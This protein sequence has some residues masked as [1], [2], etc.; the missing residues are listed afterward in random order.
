MARIQYRPASRS[1]GFRPQQLSTA[2]ISRMREEGNRLIQGME[3]RRRAE[4][5]QRD[6]NLRA[7]ESDARYTEQLTRENNAI[8]QRNLENEGKQRIADIQGARDQ[9]LIDEK[10][11]QSI[12]D[13]IISFSTTAAEQQA[14]RRKEELENMAAEINSRPLTSYSREELEQRIAAEQTLAFGGVQNAVE[15][16]AN[17]LETNEDPVETKKAHASNPGTTAVERQLVTNNGFLTSGDILLTGRYNDAETEYTADDGT[18]FKGIEAK[19]SRYLSEQLFNITLKDLFKLTGVADGLYVADAVDKLRKIGEV[20]HNQA[21]KN[22]G[23]LADAQVESTAKNIEAA[24]TTEAQTLAFAHRK[25]AQGNVEALDAFE[26]YAGGAVDVDIEVFRQVDLKGN[27]K[28]FDQEWPE[29]WKKILQNR[30]DAFVKQQDQ[31][32]KLKKA[33]DLAWFNANIDNIQEAVDLNPHQAERLL[34]ERYN[35]LGITMPQPLKSIV[36]EGL[37]RNKEEVQFQ[38]D[39]RTKYGILDTSFV[40][41]IRDRTQQSLAR[42]A[43]QT[44]EEARYGPA[45]L[46]IKKGFK[47]TARKLTKINPNEEQ[48]SAQT[49]LVQA[50]LESE[51]LKQVKLTNDPLAALENVNAMVDAGRNGD[52][53]SPFY[54]D[55]GFLNNRLVFPNIE[56]SD[57]ERQEKNQYIDKQTLRYGRTVVDKP[58]A[59]ASS[60]EMDAAYE[61]SVAGVIKYPA[62]ILRVADATGMK[63]S[64]VYNAHRMANN[65]AT[66]D[67][68]PML[69]DS[70]ASV[71]VDNV[72]PKIRK[73]LLSEDPF[74]VK[75]G[76]AQITGDLGYTRQERKTIDS[77]VDMG[78]AAGAKFPEL[79]AAQMILESALGTATSGTNNFFGMKAFGD[80]AFTEKQT[81]EFYDGV[82]EVETAYFKNYSS[83]EESVSDLVT[84]WYKDYPGY[85]GI[86][87]ATSLEEAAM[88]LQEQGYATDPNYAQKLIEIA[89]RIR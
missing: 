2:G 1:K 36:A 12:F 81:T 61:S 40:N 8:Q 33:E 64:E 51:F 27:G 39:Q 65:A 34:V 79:V 71:I 68:K 66:G 52:K 57:V 70:P 77:F 29:R 38:I 22:E 16:N 44:Q 86:N 75:Q 37:K 10:A 87:N 9:S 73:L 28:T 20:Y 6:Q 19:N 83:P 76:I 25:L 49:F 80:E 11:R 84:K 67:N 56:T 35:N 7:M 62:G 72:S 45:S 89:N 43:L 3:R 17:A 55:T 41:S 78:A 63:P 23:E 60:L 30:D 58:F 31:D 85:Q 32:T 48:G 18:K 21:R 53:S 5:E 24:N 46:G 88:M 42:E 14:R 47:A 74:K 13:S 59:L 26:K 15:I 82:E 69:G 50:R 54:Q 4:K